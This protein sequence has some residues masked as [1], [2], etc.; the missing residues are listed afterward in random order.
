MIQIL[1]NIMQ[2][3]YDPRAISDFYSSST[4]E[5]FMLE[6]QL[7]LVLFQLAPIHKCR[8]A[9]RLDMDSAIEVRR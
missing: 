7:T 8:T 9:K 6:I 4:V 2:Y 3:F 5:S 1:V